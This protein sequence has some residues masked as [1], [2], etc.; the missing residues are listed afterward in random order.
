MLD[1]I[2]KYSTGLEYIWAFLPED[3]K[4]TG[5]IWMKLG[6]RI[7]RYSF[8]MMRFTND[9]IKAG[10]P[11]GIYLEQVKNEKDKNDFCDII[12]ICFE[13]IAGHRRLTFDIM[14]SWEK[15][16]GHW[17]EGLMLLKKDGTSIGTVRLQIDDDEHGRSVFLESLAIL[18]EH[19]RQGLAAKILRESC[20]ITMELGL[21]KL[22]LS[23]NAENES[24][25]DLYL[26]EGF[27]KIST[28][29]CYGK[30][31]TG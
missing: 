20:R 29:V 16:P 21:N 10:F 12:N 1:E 24:A 23:V 25:A 9:D 28:Y 17:N 3:K 8:L 26:R 11:E 4:E 14:D 6:F 19:Q 27:K 31:L 2:L 18:P 15:E 7:D 30:Q 5:N 13:N 22:F